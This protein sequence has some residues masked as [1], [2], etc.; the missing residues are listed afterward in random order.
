MLRDGGRGRSAAASERRWGSAL[1]RRS[2]RRSRWCCSSPAVC[3][4]VRGRRSSTTSLGYRT[5]GIARL[6]ITVSRR[7]RETKRRVAAF[8]ERHAD[9]SVG[10]YPG[11]DAVG[12]VWPTL[13]PWDGYRAHVRY[14]G[15]DSRVAGTRPRSRRPRR[16]TPA[17][18]PM[19]GVPM[20]AGRNLQAADGARHA[21]RARQPSAGRSDR[22]Y[23]R[24]RSIARSRL[25]RRSPMP[26]CP[27]GSFRVVG[28]VG[29]RR[30]RRARRAGHASLHPLRR[31]DR[32]QGVA[33]R[34][35]PV[36]RRRCRRA[37]SRSACVDARRGGR[38][39]DPLRR[40]SA[41]WRRRRGALDRHHE[42]RAGARIRAV[43]V[44]RGAGRAFST[45]AL[46]LTA[47]GLFAVLSHAVAR[48]SQEIGLRVALGASRPDVVRLVLGNGLRRSRSASGSA[49]PEAWR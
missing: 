35:L 32:R 12:L 15:L 8:Y 41:S 13:P 3:C 29:E 22:R 48:R 23:R 21:R 25:V 1:D 45:T 24:P 27:S 6:A 26:A 17:C 20:V 47:I 31:F 36:A 2:R 46:A 11:V 43:A 5:D 38:A 33:R 19:L 7:T 28:V 42:R 4:C 44:L 37:S 30:L 14:R 40:A 9:C 18:S 34:R 16:P 10:Q 49:W 39:I